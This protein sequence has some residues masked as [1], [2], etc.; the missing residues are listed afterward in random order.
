VYCKPFYLE[1]VEEMRAKCAIFVN[2]I[3]KHKPSLLRPKIH[4]LLHLAH[5]MKDFGYPSCFNTE[6]SFS[7]LK[8]VWDIQYFHGGRK[9]A[10]SGG[11]SNKPL[12]IITW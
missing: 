6:R 2:N 1:D 5:N 12:P 7:F 3:K 10:L 8:G 11:R 4:L 9:Y